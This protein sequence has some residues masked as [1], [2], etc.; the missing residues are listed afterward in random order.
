VV[1][2]VHPGLGN[3]FA[4]RTESASAKAG[5]VKFV[6]RNPQLE[7]KHD[8]HVEDLEGNQLGATEVIT[9]GSASFTLEGLEPGEY[10]F[11]CSVPG[12]RPAGME[13]TLTVE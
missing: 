9:E 5:E 8:L 1:I 7:V 13:G 4:F 10:L 6:L 3:D 11:F 2:E 12:H